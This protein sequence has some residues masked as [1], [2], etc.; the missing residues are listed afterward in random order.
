MAR[1][2]SLETALKRLTTAVD[3]LEAASGRLAQTGAEKADLEQA[4]ALMQEDRGR[5]AQDLDAALFRA[6]SLDLA[7]EQV[8]KRL[9]EAGNVLRHLL[10]E[11]GSKRD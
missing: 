5:L 6:Q 10:V 7:N 1:P 11:A 9:S 4:L 3:Q 8:A 2:A